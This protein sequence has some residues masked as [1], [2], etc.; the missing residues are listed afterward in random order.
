MLFDPLLQRLRP[1]PWSA[2][3]LWA[4]AEDLSPEVWF[5]IGEHEYNNKAMNQAEAWWNLVPRQAT[6]ASLMI[7]AR[8]M[9]L[10]SLGSVAW[11]LRQMM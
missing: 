2:Q 8:L 1:D 7:A 5:R 6:F 10:R 3:H 11:V 4:N 9:T